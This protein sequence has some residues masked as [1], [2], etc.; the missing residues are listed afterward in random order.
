MRILDCF[1]Y[2]NE[3]ELLE[4]RINLLYDY[5]DKFIICD[6]NRT[7]SGRIKPFTCKNTLKD[8]N[9]LGDKIEVVEVDLSSLDNAWHRERMQRN[10]AAEFIQEKDICYIA[11]CDE[12][13]NPKF[14]KYYA[15]V[16]E[17]NPDNILRVPLAFLCGKADLRVCDSIGKPIDWSAPY[18]CMNSHLK[19][20]SLSDIRESKSIG[21]SIKFSDIF[22]TENNQILESGWHFS[23]MGDLER[24][25]TKC[26][27]FYHYDEFSVVEDYIADIDSTDPLGRKDHIL[28]KYSTNLLPQKIYELKNVHNFLLPDTK[29]I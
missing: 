22:I 28:K 13:I 24:M 12:I 3:K 9:L 2:F 4:L 21:R 25:K 5:V 1:P 19:E 18:F 17:N 20:Y 26:R 27:S 10:A 8:L 15:S 6:A 7:H 23:W 11:D 14:I 16:C 29:Q